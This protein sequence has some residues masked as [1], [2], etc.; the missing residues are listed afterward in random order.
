[1]TA[2]TRLLSFG[3]LSLS[4]F[5]GCSRQEQPKKNVVLVV[6]DTLRAD[7]MSLLGGERNTTPAIEEWAKNGVTFE[8]ASAASSWTV[9]S[10]GMLLT[11][12]YRFGPGK[13]LSDNQRLLSQ[14]LQAVGYQ[15]VGIIANPVLNSLQGFDVGYDRYE[16]TENHYETEETER[17]WGWPASVVVDKGISWLSS[18]GS[19]Q[20]F[21]LYLHLMDPHFPYKPV[22]GVPESWNQKGSIERRSDYE[23]ALM[24]E[25]KGSISDRQYRDMEHQLAAYDAEILQ[26]DAE[27][28]RLFV[29]L[30]ESGLDQETIVVLTADHGEGLWSHSSADGWVNEKSFAQSIVPELYRGHGEQLYEELIHVPLCIVGPGVPQGVRDQRAVSL[31]D[32]VPTIL[33]LL[34]L[35]SPTELHGAPL[36]GEDAVAEQREVYSNCAR[37]TSVIVDGRWKLHLPSDQVS[38]RGGHTVLF[39]LESDPTESSPLDDPARTS[40]LTAKILSW[41]ERSKE[42]GGDVSLDEQRA[43]LLQMGY[44]GL[45]NELDEETT[46]ERK[47]ELLQQDR[48]R[49]LKKQPG[50]RANEGDSG[51]QE[52]APGEPE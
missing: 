5:A 25:H 39:D 3:L 34:D 8:N 1:V 28:D 19:E 23:A 12:R 9:P 16:L 2:R 11:G 27:L 33:S 32:V 22:M 17:R 20:P 13:T 45:A 43:L 31:V 4:L 49:R 47:Q 14:V 29:F 36:V 7:R 44:V 41:R 40:A 52:N 10:M 50:Y 48:E 6:I 21:L 15:T 35:A 18:R 46:E 38:K 30:R 24:P 26:A 51:S 37:G 42:Q